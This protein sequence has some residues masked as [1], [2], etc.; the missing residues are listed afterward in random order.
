MPDV[1]AATRRGRLAGFA[2]A[3]GTNCWYGVRYAHAARFAAPQDVES[4]PGE[5]SA[6]SMA[7]QCPQLFTGSAK[8]ARLSAPD[9]GEDCLA[10]NIW[11][12][13]ETRA[14]LRPV[15]FWIHGG[16]FLAG[17][18][19]AYDGSELARSG[20]IV[21]VGVNYRL[22]VLGF[23]N[24]GETLESS[25]LPSNL[26]LRDQLAAL[27]WVRENIAAFGGDPERITIAGESAG[28]LSVS[29][30]MLCR[31]AWPLFRGAI[32]QSGALSL[33][34]D[35]ERSVALARR[36]VEL[37][38]LKRG[39]VS[40]MR[41]LG[42]QQLFAAQ[43]AV[44]AELTNNIA[45]AP[46]YDGDLLPVDLAAARIAPCAAVPILAGSNQNEI[47]L[48]ELLP[49]PGI[50]ATR[51][52]DVEALLRAQLPGP[53]AA[54]V[55]Q[56]YPRTTQGGRDLATDLNFGMPTRHFAA[57]HSSQHP[58]WFY[59]FD[60]AHPIAGASHGLDLCFLWPYR[61]FLAMLARGG[62]MSG[63]RRALSERMQGHWIHF[64]KHGRPEASWPA[65][66]TQR[67]AT[68]LFDYVDSVV[69]DPEADRRSAW[70]GEDVG[71]GMLGKFTR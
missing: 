69:E 64:V 7:P 43:A 42:L 35:R 29:L 23:V 30:L 18:S 11:A 50:L 66:D 70:Q 36:Y 60:Y 53:V 59:R 46:W 33:I 38:G 63:K 68:L 28:S 15:L 22:G 34:H 5:R 45:A 16:A 71:P 37:L 65:Y 52:D 13:A 44:Q 67:R 10:L 3:A 19:N 49:G 4:W 2:N 57:R 6:R 21:V 31:E 54:Q 20:D 48:F 58:T 39:D 8:R 55:A 25:E 61:G 47:R 26:G 9:F 51:R 14:A 27:K 1:I 40:Q 56:A 12:P 41:R 24:F 62:P 17:G 32:L